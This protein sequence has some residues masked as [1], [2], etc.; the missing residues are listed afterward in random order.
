MGTHDVPANNKSWDIEQFV[1]F[2]ENLKTDH[3]PLL[4]PNAI[5]HEDYVTGMSPSI[6][7]ADS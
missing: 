2:S 5:H 7:I 4:K 1:F 3:I 6:Q